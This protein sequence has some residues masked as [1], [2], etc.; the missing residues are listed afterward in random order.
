MY[1]RFGCKKQTKGYQGVKRRG[2]KKSHTKKIKRG[3]SGGKKMRERNYCSYNLSYQYDNTSKL[4]EIEYED[5]LPC[6]LPF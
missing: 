5:E 1:H 4:Y 6:E 3:E 2:S